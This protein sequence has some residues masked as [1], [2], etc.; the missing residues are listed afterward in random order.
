M[1]V[2]GHLVAPTG[3]LGIPLTPELYTTNPPYLD[4]IRA[5]RLR[6]LKATT[7]FFWETA[8]LDRRRGR[9]AADLELPLLLLQGEDDAMMDVA[10][11]RHWF[12][13]L[14]VGDKTYRAYPGA[15]HTLDFEPDR[16][17]YLADMLDWLSARVPSATPRPAG[18]GA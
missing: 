13:R 8:R 5:D 12:S 18:G 14:G 2:V 16:S 4:A 11:T 9:A 6:L 15:G 3:R 7:R 17:R 10:G 1:V